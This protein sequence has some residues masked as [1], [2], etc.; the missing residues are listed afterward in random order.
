MAV[1]FLT[2]EDKVLSYDEQTLTEEQKAQARENI[3]AAPGEAVRAIIAEHPQALQTEQAGYLN[4]SGAYEN[5]SSYHSITTQKIPC[6]EGDVFV[7]IGAGSSNAHS[8][9][10]Y[11]DDEIVSAGQSGKN[12]TETLVE[13]D[14]EI[15]ANVNYVRFSSF[16]A[17]DHDVTLSVYRKTLP[18]TEKLAEFAEG[19][20]DMEA[21][22]AI[23]STTE[24][25]GYF[26]PGG[27][28]VDSSSHHC[29]TTEKIPCQEG[30]QFIY[31][32]EGSY[33]AQS[34]Y[35]YNNNSFVSQGQF[36]GETTVVVPSGVNYVRFTSYA[37]TNKEIILE[38]TK[39]NSPPTKKLFELIDKINQG[40]VLYGKKYVAV[41]DSFTEGDFSGW[42]DEN[43]LSGTS[44]PVIYDSS[45]KM[46]KTYPWWIAT[47]N[48]MT[49]INEGKC[50]GVMPLSKQ[51]IAG[52]QSITY[53]NP[54]S[55]GRY[56]SVPEDADYLTIWFGI[57]DSS[58]TNLGTVEDTTNETFYGAYNVVLEWLLVNRPALKIGLI[59]TTG[60][61]AAY[62]QAVRDI[63]KRWGIPVLD[64]MGEDAPTLFGKEEGLCDTAAQIY[65]D[66]FFVTETNGHP[67]IL[68]HENMST[69]IEAFLRRL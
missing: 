16:A 4:A 69:Y 38:V 52:E 56:L 66:K 20:C 61:T 24:N 63:G 41:G 54:Y 10:L 19:F 28:I 39:K 29:K 46:Y 17:Q 53:R 47:R 34:W 50:G 9:L 15:P 5:E 6:K 33:S 67:N 48:N 13:T 21:Q 18:Q 35:F 30:D 51:Y 49:L 68:A 36:N 57:N 64:M 55:N 11:K 37:A 3:G 8:W 23:Y 58:N 14:V 62:R 42:T 59:V 43:G 45:K 12:Y 31:K 40:N 44:S 27:A 1:T 22:T 32:G 26:G 60:A 25:V 2:N 65:R 7:Y